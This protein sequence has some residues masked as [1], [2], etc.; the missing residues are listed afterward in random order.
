MDDNTAKLEALRAEFDTLNAEIDALRVRPPQL[1]D[2]W[3]RIALCDR[4]AEVGHEIQIRT[5]ANLKSV[6][7]PAELG[8]RSWVEFLTT[9]MHITSDEAQFQLSEVALL[10]A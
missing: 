3:Q 6:T 1:A 4:A 5:L 2:L 8:A 9:R 10:S 7:T